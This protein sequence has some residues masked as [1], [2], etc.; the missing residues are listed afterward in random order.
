MRASFALALA[1][2]APLGLAAQSN[3]DA[4]TLGWQVRGDR[5]T[6]DT[7]VLSF[8]EMKPG[9]HITTKSF[10][11]IMYHP[12]MTGRGTFEATMKVYF[13]KPQSEHNEA[14][15]LFVGGKDLAG[16]GQ[17]Y[18]YFLLRNNGQFLI[19]TRNGAKTTDVMPWTAHEAIKVRPADAPA[20]E[21]A[22][23]TLNIRATN[24]AVQFLVNGV[25]VATRP[26]TELAV[27]GIVGIRANHF[28]DLHVSEIE[29]ATPG[30]PT[31]R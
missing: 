30:A 1:T 20:S 22:L 19:K 7:S 23:N 12:E 16:D 3:P 11:G 2:L 10:S 24:D 28:L 5:P 29:V 27:D 21:T 25:I 15:G 6:T 31:M 13:F 14:Y 18:V 17:Q 9:F 4:R 26:R 8:V